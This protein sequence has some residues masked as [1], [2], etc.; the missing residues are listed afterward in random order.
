[1]GE[2]AGFDELFCGG[3]G[4]VSWVVSTGVVVLGRGREGGDVPSSI[5]R[6]AIEQSEREERGGVKLVRIVRGEGLQLVKME[7]EELELEL[8]GWERWGVA[9]EVE[10]SATKTFSWGA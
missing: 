8:T 2:D 6:P 5:M 3:E 1:M 9:V 7:L 4:G 10:D